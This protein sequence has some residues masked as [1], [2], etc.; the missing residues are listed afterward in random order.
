M[1]QFVLKLNQLT[2]VHSANL[3]EVNSFCSPGMEM[4][5][6]WSYF[7]SRNN[8]LA[9]ELIDFSIQHY[10]LPPVAIYFA[11]FAFSCS[12]A[13]SYCLSRQLVFSSRIF[14][15][16]DESVKSLRINYFQDGHP[17]NPF[18]MSILI[19][20]LIDCQDSLLID[21]HQIKIT[22]ST[23]EVIATGHF[24]SS[25]NFESFYVTRKDEC[26]SS[27]QNCL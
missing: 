10:S 20:C 2:I 3:Y 23:S 19:A 7:Y 14:L 26:R 13:R 12:S 15:S 25:A 1:A 27:S 21:S 8:C 17:Q 6:H 5:R 18:H 22:N 24:F 9:C 4:V 16:T 11:C